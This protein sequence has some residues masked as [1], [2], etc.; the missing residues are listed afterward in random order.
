[1]AVNS[2]FEKQSTIMQNPKVWLVAASVL[3]L[4][5]CLSLF[6]KLAYAPSISRVINITFDGGLIVQFATFDI[7]RYEQNDP[8]HFN[9]DIAM[10]VV[11]DLLPRY[12][13]AST[14]SGTGSLVIPTFS[15]GC[16]GALL[17]FVRWANLV[18]D[19]SKTI[20]DQPICQNCAYHVG[21]QSAICPECGS[22]LEIR[23]AGGITPPMPSGLASKPDARVEP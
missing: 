8:S 19:D 9:I 3:L 23:A 22:T 10:P 12:R 6:V 17:L 7:R 16:V 4:L 2:G 13:A 1:V 15:I 18:R 5:N 20:Q 11:V 21:I 14:G